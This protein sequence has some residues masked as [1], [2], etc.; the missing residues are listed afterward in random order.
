MLNGISFCVKLTLSTLAHA[1]I[2]SEIAVLAIPYCRRSPARSIIE[3]GREYATRLALKQT[4]TAQALSVTIKNVRHCEVPISNFIV[5]AS[6]LHPIP[7]LQPMGSMLLHCFH[8]RTRNNSATCTLAHHPHKPAIHC[9]CTCAL[10]LQPIPP[11]PLFPIAPSS[12]HYLSLSPHPPTSFPCPSTSSSRH[13]MPSRPQAPRKSEGSFL[14]S[15]RP[16][17]RTS[18]PLSLS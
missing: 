9:H 14:I 12:S 3:N 10:F 2:R 6:E 18:L 4:T 17:P 11:V 13:Q 16:P 7:L 5:Y 8:C 1:S 15:S